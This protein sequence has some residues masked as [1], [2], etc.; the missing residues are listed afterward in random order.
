M[1]TV[2]FN[3]LLQAAGRVAVLGIS[4]ISISLLTRYLGVSAFGQFNL[5]IVYMALFMTMADAGL[6]TIAVREL[7]SKRADMNRFGLLLGLRLALSTAVAILASLVVFLLPYEPAVKIVAAIMSITIITNGLTATLMSAL[8]ARLDF[9]LPVIIDAGSK[10][11]TTLGYFLLVTA[12]VVPQPDYRL[13]AVGIIYVLASLISLAV[14]LL[15]MA[16]TS[17][18]VRLRYDKVVWRQLFLQSA[19]L[20]IVA[21][22]GVINYRLDIV[23]LSLLKEPFVV[24]IYS[25][26][27]RFLEIAL[28]FA[29]FFIATTFPLFARLVEEKSDRIRLLTQRSFDFL[30]LASLPIAFGAFAVAPQLVEIIGGAA[31]GESVLPLRIL[32][33]TIPLSFASSMLVHIIIAHNMQKRIIWVVLTSITI[34]LVLN[35]TFIPIYSYVAAATATLISEIVGFTILTIL[36][37]R[38]YGIGL[39]FTYFLKLV[40][41]TGLMMALA[42]GLSRFGLIPAVIVGAVF[43]GL[44]VVGLRLITMDDLRKLKSGGGTA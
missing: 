3:T 22:L 31:F 44:M 41:I 36:I 21:I 30:M 15:N 32:L 6:N 24:G 20:A 38:W 9:R 19:P 5:V 17:T 42:F 12:F 2:A 37:R 14:V 10:V 40:P 35:L 33:L 13:Y 39:S 16:R 26:A 34:N 25:I 27:Y 23:I 7:A 18:L 29:G 28:P 4:L 43:Y 1:R 11:F 8:Q